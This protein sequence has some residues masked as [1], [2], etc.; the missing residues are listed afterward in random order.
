MKAALRIIAEDPFDDRL[1]L[2]RLRTSDTERIYRL[3]IQHHRVVF[4]VRPDAVHVMRVFHRRD[5]YG[6]SGAESYA[7][8]A[9]LPSAAARFAWQ[10]SR[11]ASCAVFRL[12]LSPFQ[13][14][15]AGSCRARP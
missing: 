12:A 6:W 1:D 10:R 9:T 11:R 15:R 4:V 7:A 14:L 5:G 3:R 2:Q 13:A 8:T